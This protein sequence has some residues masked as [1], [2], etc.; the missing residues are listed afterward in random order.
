MIEDYRL[1]YNSNR[2]PNIIDYSNTTI[3][4]DLNDDLRRLNDLIELKRCDENG[5]LSMYKQFE[6]MRKFGA[7]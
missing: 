4:G 1:T 3:D 2:A 6:K 7:I 5:S